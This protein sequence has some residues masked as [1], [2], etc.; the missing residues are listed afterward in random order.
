MITQL[1]KAKRF[2]ALHERE[3]AFVMP[4]PWDVGSARLAIHSPKRKGEPG[5]RR[6]QRFESK[7]ST[8]V[9]CVGVVGPGAMALLGVGVEG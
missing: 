1:E 2:Q 6:R 8:F 3:G 9:I 7:R 4:N 5:T